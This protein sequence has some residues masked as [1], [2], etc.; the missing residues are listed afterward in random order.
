GGTADYPAIQ[1][2]RSIDLCGSV[3][4]NGNGDSAHSRTRFHTDA[5][6]AFPDGFGSVYMVAIYR[7]VEYEQQ[8]GSAVWRTVADRRDLL[9][10]RAGHGLCA[11][12]VAVE[13]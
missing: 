5:D 13:A 12:C 6:R 7:H 11:D 4:G 3:V 1:S 8:P 9:V 10:D 2:L